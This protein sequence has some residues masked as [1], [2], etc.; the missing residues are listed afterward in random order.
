[1]STVEEITT[2][3]PAAPAVETLAQGIERA[4]SPVDLLRNSPARPTV[5]PVAPEFSNWRSEQLSWRRSCA[6]LDQSHHMTDLFITGPDAVRLVSE[7][8]VNTFK[9]FTVGKAKQ[10]I[11][12]NAQG[13]LIGDAILFHLDENH[14]DLVGHPMV[15]DW[16]QFQAETGGYDVELERDGNSIVRPGNPTLYRYELQGPNAL[17]IVEALTG[18]SVPD[19]KFFNMTDF[20]I[21]DRRVRALRHG[22][23][24]QPGFELFGPW[25]EGEAVR[26]AILAAGEAFDLVPVGAKGYS[27]ANLESGWVPAPLPAVFTSEDTADYRNWL[28]TARAGSLGGSF[29]SEDIEDYYLT[30]YDLGYAR[31]VSFDHEFIGRDALKERSENP[32]RSKVTL[33]WN[34]EDVA[35]AHA[36]LFDPE[37]LPAK[38]IDMPKARYALHHVD[39]VRRDGRH[40]GLSLDCGYVVNERAFVSLATLDDEH[41]ANGTEVVVTWGEDPNSSK[42]Q[43]EPHRQVGIRATV[44]PAPFLE[45]ARS[46]YRAK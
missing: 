40:A 35:A 12:V 31:S 42:P 16:V 27:S 4:G 14:L 45:Y 46:G 3:A 6:L 44:A 32:G 36:T 1:L 30:P 17:A 7:T 24:G 20:T 38:Y 25:A 33:I 34:A 23:A 28:T 19:V 22:M 5:F 21:A 13:Q 39:E 26:D 41:T 8:G 11:A 29:A 10:F 43:V 15:I 2:T 9:N 37:S 18:G